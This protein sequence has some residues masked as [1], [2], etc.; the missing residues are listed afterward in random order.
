MEDRGKEGTGAVLADDGGPAV[1]RGPHNALL[2]DAPFPFSCHL[3]T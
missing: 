2:T 1:C 3:P